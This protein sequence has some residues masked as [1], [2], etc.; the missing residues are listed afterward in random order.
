MN[1]GKIPYFGY[2]IFK[3]VPDAF[4]PNAVGP[5]DPGYLVGPGDVLRLSVW[6]QVEFQYEL[7]VNKEGKIFIPVV[8]QVFVTGVPFDSLQQKIKNLLS[9]HYSGLAA[10]PPR[11]FMDLSVAQL[12]PYGSLL[13]EVYLNISQ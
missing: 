4:R 12:R 1:D 10:Y 7:T 11:T 3:N 9:K 13:W 2:S 6:G 8:G 5:V